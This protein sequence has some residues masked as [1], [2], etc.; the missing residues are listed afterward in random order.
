[1]VT[2]SVPVGQQTN[3]QRGCRT[4]WFVQATCPCC[5]RL[6]RYGSK[7]ARKPEVKRDR[8]EAPQQ[9]AHDRLLAPAPRCTEAAQSEAQKRG[10]ATREPVAPVRFQ[11]ESSSSVYCVFS[12]RRARSKISSGLSPGA[13]PDTQISREAVTFRLWLGGQQ[14]ME[15]PGRCRCRAWVKVKLAGLRLQWCC[16]N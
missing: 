16:D 7:R 10:A 11:N 8:A 9:P 12:D 1:M 15:L 6:R 2:P 5:V 4:V 3:T 14:G 13:G